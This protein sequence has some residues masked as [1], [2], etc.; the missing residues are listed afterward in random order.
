MD[1]AVHVLVIL[2]HAI[3][4][5]LTTISLFRIVPWNI[6]S[7]QCITHNVRNDWVVP[8]MC[9]LTYDDPQ[10]CPTGKLPA[11]IGYLFGR[12]PTRKA[13]EVERLIWNKDVSICLTHNE[14]ITQ[15]K[16]ESIA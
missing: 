6:L 13:M 8:T 7:E 4:R 10:M 3:D 2:D 1:I 15:Y 16:R 12:L 9:A 11:Q 14:S 5:P